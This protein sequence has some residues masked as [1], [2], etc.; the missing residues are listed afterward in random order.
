MRAL[1]TSDEALEIDP[2]EIDVRTGE[3]GQAVWPVTF[4]VSYAGELL[5]VGRATYVRVTDDHPALPEPLRRVTAAL[6]FPMDAEGD[7]EGGAAAMEPAAAAAVVERLHAGRHAV[8]FT[9]GSAY[10]DSR[11]YRWDTAGV[12][13]VTGGQVVAAWLLPL[14]QPAFDRIWSRQPLAA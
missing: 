3:D 14:D 7:A 12:Y 11:A 8:H 5:A 6:P 9:T 2:L 10:R 4:M 13:R 1:A